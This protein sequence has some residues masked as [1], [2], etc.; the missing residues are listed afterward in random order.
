MNGRLTLG[1]PARRV[2]DLA[3]LRKGAPQH[4]VDDARYHIPK[5]PLR[6]AGALRALQ[7]Q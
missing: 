3:L 1:G 2:C 5:R 7:R 4:P 6:V